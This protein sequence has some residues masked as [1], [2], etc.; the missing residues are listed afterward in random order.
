[1]NILFCV[2]WRQWRWCARERGQWGGH[3]ARTPIRLLPVPPPPHGVGRAVGGAV[4][5]QYGTGRRSAGSG[6]QRPR[7]GTFL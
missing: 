4:S 1:M 5:R 7:K 2:E 6:R 3:V